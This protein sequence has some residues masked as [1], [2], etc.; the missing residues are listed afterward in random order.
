M[1]QV[2]NDPDRYPDGRRF[3]PELQRQMVCVFGHEHMRRRSFSW[4]AARDDEAGDSDD[5]IPF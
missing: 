4:H 5:D 3:A 2:L 1:R